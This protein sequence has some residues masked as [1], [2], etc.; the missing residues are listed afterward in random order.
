MLKTADTCEQHRWHDDLFQLPL[1]LLLSNKIFLVNFK[2]HNECTHIGVW[3]AEEF[4]SKFYR[5]HNWLSAFLSISFP[6]LV[7]V[8]R[9]KYLCIE[10]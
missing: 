9:I 10:K 7:W 8:K 5:K 4:C 2:F 3:F 6:S 1:H